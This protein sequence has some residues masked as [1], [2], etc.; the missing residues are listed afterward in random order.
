MSRSP[1]SS[2]QCCDL[3]PAGV[4]ATC[5]LINLAGLAPNLM[6]STASSSDARGRDR[7][8]MRDEEGK[9][10]QKTEESQKIKPFNFL[11]KDDNGRT[12]NGKKSRSGTQ[13][14]TRRM[15]KEAEETGRK[16]FF[17]PLD[18]HVN[19]LTL[20]DTHTYTHTLALSLLK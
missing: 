18:K 14:K 17:R 1:S 4:K 15:R 10:G 13:Q 2:L 20:T 7:K 9:N 11:S 12:C 8:R 3:L 6:T 19:H 5:S 16:G